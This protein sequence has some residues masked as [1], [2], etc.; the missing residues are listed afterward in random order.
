[1]CQSGTS[2]SV[3]FE[4]FSNVFSTSL[5]IHSYQLSSHCLVC[6]MAS[7]KILNQNAHHYVQVRTQNDVSIQKVSMFS[8]Q[9][10]ESSA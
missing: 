6:L 9:E 1:M 2:S 7:C 5:S 10:R 8:G 4:K 3:L